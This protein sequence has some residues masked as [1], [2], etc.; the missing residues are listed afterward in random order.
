[1]FLLAAPAGAQK[2]DEEKAAELKVA[3]I[4][5]IAEFTSWPA[6]VFEGDQESLRLCVLGRDPFG[7][8]EKIEDHIVQKKR[9][10]KRRTVQM[11]RL[12]Y[13][14]PDA[15][16]SRRNFEQALRQCHVLYFTKWTSVGWQ[17]VVRTLRTDPVVTISGRKNFSTSDGMIEF[18]LAPRPG[19]G[20]QRGID[21]SIN[22]KASTRAGLRLSSRL[23]SLKRGVNIVEYPDNN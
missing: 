11:R 3:Y 22:L 9:P 12:R 17:E 18:V 13:V 10:I 8:A 14:A 4:R 1:M 16:E 5:Y 7:V 6:G 19:K 15:G 21:L 23:L 20:N 2:V